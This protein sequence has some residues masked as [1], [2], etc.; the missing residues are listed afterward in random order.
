MARSLQKVSSSALFVRLL[1]G[2]LDFYLLDLHE[3]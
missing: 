3:L 1:N 2:G